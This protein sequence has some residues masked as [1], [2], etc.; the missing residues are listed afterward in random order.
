[1]NEIVIIA[2]PIANK[3]L[4]EET[5]DNLC[6]VVYWKEAMLNKNGIKNLLFNLSEISNRSEENLNIFYDRADKKAECLFLKEMFTSVYFIKEDKNIVSTLKKIYKYS[7]D[8]KGI[9]LYED[10]DEIKIIK[11]LIHNDNSI[12]FLNNANILKNRQLLNEILMLR[13]FLKSSQFDLDL[14]AIDSSAVMGIYGL[15]RPTDI[16]YL[17]LKAFDLSNYKK[18]VDID[19]H[20]G[21]LVWHSAD[22]EELINNPENYFYAFGM[23]FISLQEIFVMKKRRAE[24]KDI[25]DCYLIESLENNNGFLCGIFSFFVT[26]KQ[27]IRKIQRNTVAFCI[28]GLKKLRVYDYVR[29]AYRKIR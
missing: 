28:S 29:K 3:K 13:D 15:R 8:K 2:W 16:D 18:H 19:E 22:K 10:I 21:E 26:C 9:Y 11:Q 17:T 7:L 27:L 6:R 23:K 4:I 1:M 20:D 5:I 25:D 24:K 12:H 14:F